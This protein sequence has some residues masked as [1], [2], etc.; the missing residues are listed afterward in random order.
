[1]QVNSAVLAQP[2]LD[3]RG[4]VGGPNQQLEKAPSP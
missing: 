2:V 1:M 3:F 4:L